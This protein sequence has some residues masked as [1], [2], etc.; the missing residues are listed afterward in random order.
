MQVEE[1]PPNPS[2]AVQGN[3]GFDGI[4]SGRPFNTKADGAVQQDRGLMAGD[5]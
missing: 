1:I 2:L 5:G 3:D 4:L